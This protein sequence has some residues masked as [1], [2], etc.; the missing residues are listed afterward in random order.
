MVE[1]GRAAT[2]EPL[3]G[4]NPVVGD[5]AYVVAPPAVNVTAEAPGWQID[6]VN[7]A[8]VTVGNAFIVSV[9]WFELLLQVPQPEHVVVIT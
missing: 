8:T 2:G 3:V 7:G 9:S 5:H 4:V 1:D 6:A